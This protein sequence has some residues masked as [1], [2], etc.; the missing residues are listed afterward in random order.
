MHSRPIGPTGAAMA[1][2][3]SM[4]WINSS[5]SNMVFPPVDADSL[6]S[7]IRSAHAVFQ[8]KY[9]SELIN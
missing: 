1:T 4:A 8:V 9:Q 2:P 7:R 6:P 3:T 5:A